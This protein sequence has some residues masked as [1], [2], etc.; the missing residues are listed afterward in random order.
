MNAF[1]SDPEIQEQIAYVA[2]QLRGMAVG[3]IGAYNAFNGD[4]YV[5]LRAR[6]RVEKEDGI[7]FG[8]VRGV[9]VKRLSASEVPAIGTAGTRRIHRAAKKTVARLSNLR[10][11]NDM[12]AADRLRCAAYSMIAVSVAEKTSTSSVKA[13]E[14]NVRNAGAA[15]NFGTILQQK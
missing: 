3:Q 11:Y 10:A 9:G 1:I 2:H 14:N 5:I 7:R 6:A 13:S 4:L 8:T 12:D 15:V